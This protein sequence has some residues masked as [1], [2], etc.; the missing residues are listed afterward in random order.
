MKLRNLLAALG[1]LVTAGLGT[2]SSTSAAAACP[3]RYIKMIIPNPAGGV[4]DLIGRILG[5]AASPILGQGFVIEN[6][7]GA[8]TTIGTA[9]VAKAKPDGCTILSL[10]AS[11]VVASVMRDKLP[12]NLEQDF[13]PIIGIGSFPMTL[14]VPSSSKIGSMAD[15]VAASKVADGIPYATGGNGTMAHLASVRMLK[16]VGGA[17]THIP[18]RGNSDAI[19]ALLGNQVQFFFSSTAE[20]LTLMKGN[21]VRVLGVTSD[22]RVPYLPSVPTMKELGFAELNPRLWYAFLAPAGTPPETVAQLY[23]AFS[24]ALSDKAVQERLNGL[25]FTTEITSP[26]QIAAYMKAEA[27]RWAKVVKDNSIQAAD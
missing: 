6:R 26:A 22:N 4:G 17:G 8:T 3:D 12:Y 21:R 11:G 27:G 20:A 1:V 16:T 14:I 10:T 24:K 19:Q 9:L 13:A 25:G 15:L 2:M 7:A 23:E 18:F 5:D